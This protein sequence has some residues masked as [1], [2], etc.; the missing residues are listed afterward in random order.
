MGAFYGRY[1]APV[2]MTRRPAVGNDRNELLTNSEADAGKLEREGDK[3][4]LLCAN[5]KLNEFRLLYF[6]LLV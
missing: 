1:L 6:G 5:A 2:G 3:S 4:Q